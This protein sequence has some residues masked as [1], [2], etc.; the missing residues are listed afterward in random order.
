MCRKMDP[1]VGDKDSTAFPR[2]SVDAVPW[3][4]VEQMREVDRVAIDGGLTLARMMENAGAALASVALALLGG[5]VRDRRVAV[6]AGRGGNGGGGLVAARRLIGWGADVEVRLSDAGDALAP[7][8][9]EQLEILRATAARV[10]VGADGLT[11][12]ELFLD[13]VLGYGQRAAPRGR[14]AELIAATAGTR[15]LSLD[16]PSGLALAERA[17]H[18]PAVGAEATVTLALP[19]A[20]L[21]DQAARPLVGRLYLAD[22][23]IPPAVYPQLGIGYRSPFARGPI[24]RLI[25]PGRT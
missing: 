4:T 18:E 17:V 19:K 12:P 7:V 10:V 15:V 5:D 14:A 2:C 22:L 11:T 20:A 3:I 13:A 23:G 9:L 16:V 25:E 8:P 24:V 1:E 21:R 6:L